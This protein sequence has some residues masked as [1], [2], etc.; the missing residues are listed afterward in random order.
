MKNT[1][2]DEF[3]FLPVVILLQDLMD[4]DTFDIERASTL[5]LSIKNTCLFP[6]KSYSLESVGDV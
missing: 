6:L 1:S 4:L 5:L 3:V 2:M